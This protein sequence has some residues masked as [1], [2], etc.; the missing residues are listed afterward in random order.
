MKTIAQ[1]V[2]TLA[3]SLGVL[4]A[5]LYSQAELSKDKRINPEGG[6]SDHRQ[7]DSGTPGLQTGKTPPV[8]W[9]RLCPVT[10]QPIDPEIYLDYQDKERNLAGRLYLCCEACKDE[11]A[12]NLSGTYMKAYRMNQRTGWPETPI[13]LQ[14]NFCPVAPM[15]QAFSKVRIEYN[16]VIFHFHCENCINSFLRDPDLALRRLKANQEGETIKFSM[17]RQMLPF[18]ALY[19]PETILVWPGF[20]S[21][22]DL[23]L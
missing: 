16:G 3:L 1:T 12:M 21:Q 6:M 9:N 14:N 2:S 18:H 22:Q 8:N 7:I 20:D 15:R 19:P 10:K 11:A 5:T 17:P 13:D 4:I 23:W